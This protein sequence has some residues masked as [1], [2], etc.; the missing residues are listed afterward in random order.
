MLSVRCSYFGEVILFIGG[1]HNYLK[2]HGFFWHFVKLFRIRNIFAI[3]ESNLR[4]FIWLA[5]IVLGLILI[6]GI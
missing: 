3:F 2:I 4:A 1:L 5:K 6:F